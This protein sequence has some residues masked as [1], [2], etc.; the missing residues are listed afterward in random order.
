MV[1]TR[2]ERHFEPSVRRVLGTDKEPNAESA[3]RESPGRGV[4]AA[5]MADEPSENEGDE[6][7]AT[8]P[9]KVMPHRRIYDFALGASWPESTNLFTK[10]MGP[11]GGRLGPISSSDAPWSA[12]RC[13]Y[14]ANH[15]QR[16]VN[17]G[18]S[19]RLAHQLRQLGD[20]GGDAPRLVTGEQ[21]SSRAP[22]GLLL[23]IDTADQDYRAGRVII[24]TTQVDRRAPLVS[25]RPAACRPAIF[26]VMDVR[27]RAVRHH[28]CAHRGGCSGAALPG[29]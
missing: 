3:D 19:S 18:S 7:D 4:V 23:E 2:Q 14:L 5:P 10:E 1:V 28:Q 22:T 26:M 6:P 29:A 25:R 8:N 11:L 20:V 12:A 16:E 24:P 21:V 27:R 13:N 15:P 9:H 17:G